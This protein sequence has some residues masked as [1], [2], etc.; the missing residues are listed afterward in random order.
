MNMKSKF[1]RNIFIWILVIILIFDL[2]IY[3][4]DKIISPSVVSYADMEIKREVTTIVNQKVLEEYSKEFNYDKIIT[5]EKDDDGNITMLRAD[6]LKMNRI[7]CDVA[8]ETQKELKNASKIKV[9]VPLGYIFN[10]NIIAFS[11]PKIPVYMEPVGYI[12]TKYVSKFESAGINQT[13][14]KI[15]VIVKTN[16]RVI[17]P[18]KNDEIEVNSEIPIAETIIVGKIPSTSIGLD[19]NDGGVK[20]KN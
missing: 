19:L 5:V 16:I 6:T 17:V 9:S 15:N 4:V 13:R 14:H 12:E 18:S 2:L 1:K 11:G 20:L 8:L 3:S 7:A 10:N